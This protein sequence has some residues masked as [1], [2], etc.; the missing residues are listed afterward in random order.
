MKLFKSFLL[1]S[2]GTIERSEICSTVPFP[3]HKETII[4]I[5]KISVLWLFYCSNRGVLPLF[6]DF[7]EKSRLA[8]IIFILASLFVFI[9]KM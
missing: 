2:K 5:R 8:G 3:R 4:L 9:C 1:V 7:L 6:I